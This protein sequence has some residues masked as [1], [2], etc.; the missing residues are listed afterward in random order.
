MP[1]ERNGEYRYVW[2]TIGKLPPVIKCKYSQAEREEATF[3]LCAVI[4][5]AIAHKEPVGYGLRGNL[6]FKLG[7]ELRRWDDITPANWTI[8]NASENHT[9][10]SGEHL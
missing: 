8:L 6:L 4:S 9:N 1:L 10:N 7:Q 3:K 5:E 2:E